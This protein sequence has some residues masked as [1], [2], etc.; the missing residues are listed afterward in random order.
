MAA[1]H[2]VIDTPVVTATVTQYDGHAVA[3]RCGRVHAAAP[4]AGAG[5]A[6][7]VTYGLNLQAWAV[8]LLAVHHVPVERC[9]GVIAALTGTRPS[10]GWV[11]G[12]LARAAK[13]VR[14]EHADPGAGHHR[15]RDLRGRDPDPG[16]AGAE[17]PQEVPAGRLHEPADLLTSWAAGGSRRSTRS[18]SRTCPA[19]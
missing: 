14:G 9:A 1:S 19:A 15:R 10:D 16:R 8:F 11:H 6:G 18:C 4:Q 12:M 13:A 3:C 5:A 17:D 7:T 2:Q